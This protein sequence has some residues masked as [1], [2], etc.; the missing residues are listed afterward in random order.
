MQKTIKS[1]S[2][3]SELIDDILELQEV[4]NKLEQEQTEY[5]SHNR[6]DG[7]PEPDSTTENT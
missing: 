7:C 5:E 1:V 6:V 3:A 2:E 4:T